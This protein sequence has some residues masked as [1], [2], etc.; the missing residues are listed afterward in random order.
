MNAMVQ[1][2]G[3][4]TGRESG[5]TDIVEAATIAIDRAPGL[6][7]RR[8]ESKRPHQVANPTGPATRLCGTL[9][10]EQG[11]SNAQCYLGCLYGLVAVCR[12]I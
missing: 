12:R 3:G 4:S 5:M 7:G 8:Q 2:A 1:L 6:P 10:A 11:N 9:G